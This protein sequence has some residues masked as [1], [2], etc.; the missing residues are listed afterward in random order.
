MPSK[1][2]DLL[3]KIEELQ[4]ELGKEYEKLLKKYE[5][6]FEKGKVVFIDSVRKENILLKYNLFKYISTADFKHVI[7]MPFIYSMIV[8]MLILDIFLWVYQTFAFPLYGIQKVKR[9]EYIVH[10]RQF[11]DYLNLIQKL[12]CIYCT[13]GNGL[14]AYAVEI[15]ARTERYWC[16][17]KAARHRIQTHEYYK[18]FADYGDPKGFFEAL[19]KTSKSK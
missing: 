3:K 16:P 10:D 18:E 11:L 2:N 8:P 15:A 9:S 12:N 6:H 4:S 7:S 19:N 13:Y 14:F 1:I 5:Y 17:I